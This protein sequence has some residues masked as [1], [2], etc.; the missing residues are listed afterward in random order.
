MKNFVKA[1]LLGLVSAQNIDSQLEQ[2]HQNENIADKLADIMSPLDKTELSTESM[3]T[4]NFKKLDLEG[5]LLP[6]LMRDL[7]AHNRD[8]MDESS[9]EIE[10]YF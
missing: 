2:L 8:F 5:K 6:R 7:S 3:D 4:G 9:Y 1:L 10:N